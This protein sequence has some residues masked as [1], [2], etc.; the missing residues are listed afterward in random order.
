MG[1]SD[2]QD[3]LMVENT[4]SLNPSAALALTG[5]GK[6]QRAAGLVP[7][8]IPVT[9]CRHSQCRKAAR[10]LLYG[11]TLAACPHCLSEQ[12]RT[13]T[14]PGILH[15]A[16]RTRAV[17]KYFSCNTQLKV[18]AASYQLNLLPVFHQPGTRWEKQR[19]CSRTAA[20]LLLGDAVAL[21]F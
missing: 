5:G 12:H 18:L 11:M 3:G 20:R 15:L 2:L 8:R 14:E 13:G 1:P 21:L 17:K 9:C 19:C 10:A 16:G 4:D 6:G 7:S